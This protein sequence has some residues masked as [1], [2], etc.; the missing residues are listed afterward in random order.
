MFI[1]FFTLVF[2]APQSLAEAGTA[3]AD[4][5]AD[6]AQTDTEWDITDAFGSTHEVS[7]DT[8][9]GTWMSV[10]VH[11]DTVIFDLLGDVWALPL[12]GGDA[13]RLTSGAAWDSEPR[14]S[15]DGSRI[16]YVSDANGN[17]QIW[18]MNS[19]GSNPTLLT[20]EDTARVTDPVWDPSGPWVIARRR[21]VDTRSIGVTE[22]WQ[23]H[24]DGGNGVPL[25]TKDDHPHAGEATTDGRTIWFS[26]RNGR[27][28][29]NDD[30]LRGLW[31]VM[32]LDRVTGNLRTEVSG[33]GSAVR[34]TLLP[35]GSGLVFVSRDRNQTL[36]EHLDFATRKRRVIADWLDH[37]QMEGFAL[38]GVYPAMDWTSEGDLV[39]W[40]G[41]KLWRVSLDGSRSEIPF[42][43]QASWRIHD[44]HRAQNTIPDTVK[45]KVNRWPAMNRFGDLTYS[46]MGRLIVE[47]AGTLK[48]LGP[49]FAPRWSKDGRRLL[50]TSWSDDDQSGRLHL[51]GGRGFGRTETLPV[52]GHLTNPVFGPEGKSVVVLRDPN[53]DNRPN[54][55]S[56][57]WFELLR[58]DRIKGEWT[59]TRLAETVD[60]GVGFRAP[61]L[62]VHDERIWWLAVGERKSRSPA[63][64]DFV[65][66]NWNGH[67]R[68]THITFPG[69]VEAIPSP[70]FDRIAYKLNHQAWVAAMPQP[71][72]HAQL[73][74]L[75]KLQLTETVGDWLN[76]TP[77]GDAVT[78]VQGDVFYRQGLA[79]DR[80]PSSE[81]LD[82]PSLSTLAFQLPR[83][84]PDK[85]WAITGASVITMDGDTVID[86][87]TIVVE[88]DTIS[89]IE[90]GGAVPPGAAVMDAS[91]K[92]VIPGLI[93]VHAHMHYGSGDILPEQPWQYAVNLDFGVTTVHDPSAS[94]DVVFTQ[95]ERVEAGLSAGP[96]VYSTGYVLY[97]ALGNENAK[98]PDRTAA[99]NHVQRLKTVGATSVKVYQQ[100]R[101]DQRQ[102]YV[103]ACNELDMLCI[104]E[105]GGDLWMNL[106]MVA[107]GFHAL[108]HSLPN[109]PV[110]SDVHQFMAGS[111]SGSTGG[112]AYSPTLLVAYGGLSGE[113]YFYQHHGAYNNERLLRHWDRRALD[114]KTRRGSLTAVD[115]DWNHQ[116]VA[117]DCK[118][119]ADKGVLV[120][121]G[122]HGQ[123]QGL[124]VH[125][126]LWALA[127]P[128]AMSPLEALRAATIGGAQYLGLQHRIGSI[129]PG[130]VA[131]LVILNGDPRTDIHHTTDIHTVIKNGEIV[132]RD[133]N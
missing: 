98:T 119:L 117:R 123:L 49:G 26:S 52:E 8:T 103:E 110:Y 57:P 102:W 107:D 25:T 19:D 81:D 4:T 69:A 2:L 37:D 78:W 21:T 92:T 127:G 101:R 24:P 116:A 104:A 12:E 59:V 38:H 86:D 35:D 39:L 126:E 83:D 1:P 23:Y 121:L 82:E 44:V 88:G 115:N 114:A 18:T 40:A 72:V 125:W 124:G 15:P 16:A 34:P 6:A 89:S 51:T 105:G 133:G 45:S 93:D 118:V 70:S 112:T 58:L 95:S 99:R 109:A 73:D 47:R 13:T 84:R 77:S 31:R 113:Y 30:P 120:T 29:Y 64:S 87:A 46:A 53:Q 67:D 90:K 61:I 48:D 111:P 11:G 131:D 76:W 54:M 71:G 85:T 97:G 75:P 128:E 65:S 80:I 130:K 55:R 36:L 94:T 14:F 106:S 7:I 9:E 56:F 122:A 63:K 60:S 108:E 50:W 96:R 32:R 33:N 100:S 42:R 79:R 74:A 62:T 22:L 43:V 41:G 129:E 10:S 28:D 68:Q 3:E 66:V 27:F 132:S 17:E 20:D 5:A 91:G